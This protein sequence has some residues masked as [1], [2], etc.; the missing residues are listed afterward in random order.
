MNVLRRNDEAEELLREVIEREPDNGEAY[1]SLGLLLAQMRRME[2]AADNL[3]LASQLLP[4]RG[5]VRYNY[6]LA[7]EN[8]GAKPKALVVLLEAYEIDPYDPRIVQLLVVFYATDNDLETALEY[9]RHLLEIN[10][11]SPKAQDLADQ[12][13]RRVEHF[14]NR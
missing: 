7:L 3:A 5:R 2:E 14:R 13:E 10:P 8:L 11:D 12:L 9:A 6:A 4:H 1:Y